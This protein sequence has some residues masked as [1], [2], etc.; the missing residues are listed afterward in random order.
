MALDDV[1]TV[2]RP[3]QR[4]AAT[5]DPLALAIE[6]YS[7]V[8]EGTIARR[9]VT[10]KWIPMVSIRGT[11][12]IRDEAVGGA[13]LQKIT[14]GETPDGSG[15][16]QWGKNI[17]T[18]DSHILARETMPLLDTFQTSRDKRVE[19]GD[20]HGKYIA[21]FLD[22]ALL[23]QAIKSSLRT[24]S[25]FH[26]GTTELPGHAGGSTV[27]F[28]NAADRLDPALIVAKLLELLAKMELK[29]VDPHQDGLVI[30][31]N[32]T[33][34]YTLLQAEQ[35]VNSN[36]IT[37]MGNTVQGGFILKAYGLPVVSS[38]NYVGGTTVTGHLLSTTL[39]GDAFDGD[40]TKVFATVTSPR[41]VLAGET[42]PVTSEVF[43]G[44]K[45]KLWFIDSHFAMSA[46]QRRAE[47]AGSI[48]LP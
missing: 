20:E 2:T 7:G 23:T 41:A 40:F 19:I 4:N 42:I 33:A 9:S 13:A 45:E 12:T 26:D 14:P 11:T 1:F 5:A 15:A 21:K 34:F 10:A 18:V 16:T 3:N 30:V 25:T 44:Q 39:N 8:V 48:L 17:L 24:T 28:A 36:Y 31:L 37:A 38:S 6:E 35:L 47:F 27:V 22:S 46:T 29:D 43:Y 32:P